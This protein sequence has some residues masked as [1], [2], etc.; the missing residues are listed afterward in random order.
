MEK[1]QTIPP[2][3]AVTENTKYKDT[4]NDTA[5]IPT[6]FRVSDNTDEQVIDTGLVVYDGNDNEWVW[7]PVEDVNDLYDTITET[8]LSGNTGITTT[9]ASKSEII[10][11]IKRG[12]PGSTIRREPDIL[13]QEDNN[14]YAQVA[15]FN[16]LFDM[17]TSLAKDYQN[18]ILSVELY[19]GFYVGRY[20][21]VGSETNPREKSGPTLSNKNWYT[22]YKICKL[23][24][25]D[26][27]V[28]SR[29]IW[30]CQWD[31]ILKWMLS[32]NDD[33]VKSFV[34]NS[35]GKGNFSSNYVNTGSNI[36]Y[37]V[38]KIYDLGR[39]LYRMDSRS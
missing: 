20:E 2:T 15:G 12:I 18:M 3:T 39:Q 16:D 31:A 25:V 22:F 10:T 17:A 34:T 1:L 33:D 32:S 21:L 7:I 36:D 23:F 19:K 4:N 24:T 28:E 35:S 11:D 30:G 29:M 14:S 6:G 13:S 9:K 27:V 8:E 26:E 37:Q 38:N 5:V